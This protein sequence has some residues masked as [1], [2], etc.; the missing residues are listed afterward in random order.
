M[1]P[2][3]VDTLGY[4]SLWLAVIATIL[5]E[6]GC[7]TPPV[8][9]NVYVIAGIAPDVPMEDIFAGRRLVCVVPG[10]GGEILTIFPNIATWLP[11]LWLT[12]GYQ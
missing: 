9:L 10:S 5:I 12:L 2:V 4:S 7:I 11:L 3:V 8:G 6:I 1:H